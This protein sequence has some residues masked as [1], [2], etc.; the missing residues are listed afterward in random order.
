M[1]SKK[2][3][4]SRRAV[5]HGAAAGVLAVGV[6]VVVVVVVVP[7]DRPI[8]RPDRPTDPNV[9]DRGC[10]LFWREGGV[11]LEECL[12]RGTAGSDWKASH[13]SNLT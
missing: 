13:T 3:L 11:I 6:A 9:S 8:G 12:S 2:S 1:R 5:F 7:T 4:C 10:G